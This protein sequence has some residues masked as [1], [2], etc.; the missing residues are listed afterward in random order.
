DLNALFHVSN[1]SLLKGLKAAIAANII[2]SKWDDKLDKVLKD[3]NTLSTNFFLTTNDEQDARFKKIISQALPTA[4]L[5]VTFVNTYFSTET[6]PATFW[7]V[8][9]TQPGFTDG[10]A[11]QE[12]KTLLS[13]NHLT[14]YEPS[15]T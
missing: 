14:G 2:S 13:I 15:L 1:E 7:S 12:M 4:D 9:A 8:L 6:S 3:F 5:Q 10:K 11:I